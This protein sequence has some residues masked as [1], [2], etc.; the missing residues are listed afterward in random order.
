MLHWQKYSYQI[1]SLECSL[2]RIWEEQNSAQ[3]SPCN[4]QLYSTEALAL[5]VHSKHRNLVYSISKIVSKICA[6]EL[7]PNVKR[8]M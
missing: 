1:E 3:L 8:V 4:M 2:S 6:I 5:A 7:N